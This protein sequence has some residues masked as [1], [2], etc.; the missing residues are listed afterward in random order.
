MR[1][2]EQEGAV[3]L[4]MQHD[5]VAGLRNLTDEV[6]MRAGAL[7]EPGKRC[8]RVVPSKHVEEPRCVAPV[9]S[10]V[11]TQGDMPQA[12]ITV[13]EHTGIQTLQKPGSGPRQLTLQ[14][15]ESIGRV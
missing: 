10:V 4:P 3:S 9:R 11:I 13:P 15:D 1:L 5:L 8:H 2:L 6:G 14:S 12:R 7:A